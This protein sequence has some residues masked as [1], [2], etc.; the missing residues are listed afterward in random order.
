[1]PLG[2]AHFETV[3]NE[4]RCARSETCAPVWIQITLSPGART[5]RRTRRFVVFHLEIRRWLN[6]HQVSHKVIPAAPEQV[7][8]IPF[9]MEHTGH[10]KHV[11]VL[12]IFHQDADEPHRLD[13]VHV[14]VHISVFEQQVPLKLVCQRVV[15]LREVIAYEELVDDISFAR[16][17]LLRPHFL[18]AIKI[19]EALELRSVQVANLAE[20]LDGLSA[21]VFIIDERGNLAHS[22]A[23]G[24]EM[25]SEEKIFRLHGGRLQAVKSAANAGIATSLT[26]MRDSKRRWIAYR[27]L[28]SNRKRDRVIL[29]ICCR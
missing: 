17:G 25:L 19:G 1:M 13:R 16:M 15:R 10:K 5:R 26:Q 4:S 2:V 6:S 12:V 22:N 20:S 27:P 29:R 24:R 21:A 14:V 8:V 9:A 28:R 3:V 23:S 18:R 7:R 11:E